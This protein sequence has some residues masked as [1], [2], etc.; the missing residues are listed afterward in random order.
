MRTE[1][2]IIDFFFFI[3]VLSMSISSFQE[4][5]T[6]FSISFFVCDS[7]LLYHLL[8]IEIILDRYINRSWADIKR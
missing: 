7:M 2:V 1:S 3:S 6:A 4:E 8:A 5:S